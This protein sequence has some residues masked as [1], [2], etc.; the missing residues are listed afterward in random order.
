MRS[1][2]KTTACIVGYAYTEGEV[3]VGGGVNLY[4]VFIFKLPIDLLKRYV[5]LKLPNL[6]ETRGV[7]DRSAIA[8][9]QFLPGTV[10]KGL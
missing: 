5:G 7:I 9:G 2:R 8:V 6:E 10:S 1:T 3:E 4:Y